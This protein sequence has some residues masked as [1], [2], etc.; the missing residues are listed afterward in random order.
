MNELLNI[1][2]TSPSTVAKDYML[3]WVFGIPLIIVCLINW[4][5]HSVGVSNDDRSIG[6]LCLDTSIDALTIGL[7]IGLTF[8]YI[9]TSASI[10][11]GNILVVLVVLVFMLEIRRRYLNGN[12]EDGILRF[13]AVL[14]CLLLA[15]GVIIYLYK[16]IS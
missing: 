12:I 11:L 9:K 8:F 10:G 3:V 5:K 1:I 16:T 6:D 15:F 14:L 2:A 4:L 7:T 13:L